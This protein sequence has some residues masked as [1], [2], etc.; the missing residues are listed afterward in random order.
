MKEREINVFLPR[1]AKWM[2][3]SFKKTGSQ[4]KAAGNERAE[5]QVHSVHFRF[6]SL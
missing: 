2:L 1:I 6:V 4:V 3:V 5:G